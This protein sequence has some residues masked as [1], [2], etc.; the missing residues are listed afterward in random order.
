MFDE[1]VL[2][3]NREETFF[4]E[5]FATVWHDDETDAVVAQMT[6]YTEGAAFREYMDAVADAADETRSDCVLA[7]TRE[8]PTL[9]TADQEW[10]ATE[11]GPRAEASGVQKLATIVPESVLAEMS[12]QRVFDESPDDIEREFF[13]S[14]A[15]AKSWL[16]D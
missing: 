14:V 10:A 8:Q 2:S 1:T 4:D 15:D 11:W 12:V 3:S 9:D 16:T 7:D 5:S 13:D 6:S